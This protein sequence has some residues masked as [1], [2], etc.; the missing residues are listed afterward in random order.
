MTGQIKQA[1]DKTLD[2]IVTSFF[3]EFSK[4]VRFCDHVMLDCIYNQG[5]EKMFVIYI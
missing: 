4:S 1:K 3:G 5:N 2:K